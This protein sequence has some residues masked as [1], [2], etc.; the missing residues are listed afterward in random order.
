MNKNGAKCKIETIQWIP[1]S[2]RQC[3]EVD[4]AD[5]QANI[6]EHQ[7]SQSENQREH[8][9]LET[10]TV[11]CSSTLDELSVFAVK[12]AILKQF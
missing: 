6:K 5:I 4:G 3:S 7:N 1:S 9:R 2:D 10:K 8:Q 12:T 11:G